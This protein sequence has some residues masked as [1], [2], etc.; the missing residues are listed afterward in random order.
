VLESHGWGD[1]CTRL[2]EKAAKGDWGGMASEI[3]DEMLD[4]FAVTASWNDV[5]AKVKARYTG[6]LDR[7]A[8]YLP[9]RP[10][11]DVDRWQQIVRAFA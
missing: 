10:D 5:A 8:L 7:V 2:N 1:T 11:A 4:V 9:F 6:I 3:T